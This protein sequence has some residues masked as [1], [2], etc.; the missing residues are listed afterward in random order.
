MTSFSDTDSAIDAGSGEEDLGDF[1]E[2]CSG[3]GAGVRSRS[4]TI[5]K[6]GKAEAIAGVIMFGSD[7]RIFSIDLRISFDLGGGEDGIE[8]MED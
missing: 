4:W 5:L 3:E 8:C 2:T 7:G 1:R 6:A